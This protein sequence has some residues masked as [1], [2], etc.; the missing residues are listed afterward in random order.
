MASVSGT[1]RGRS[2]GGS[3]GPTASTPSTSSSTKVSPPHPPRP[4]L[5]RSDLVLVLHRDSDDSCR[6]PHSRSVS[7]SNQEEPPSQGKPAPPPA[8]ELH[9]DPP[10][11]FQILVANFLAQTEALM[12]GK[13][14][15]EAR[16]E[17]AAAG[18]EAAALQ[19]L[20]PHKVC[21][22]YGNRCR[23]GG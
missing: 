7:A 13:T 10:S 5:N 12:K 23:R 18:V 9:T 16:E 20:L 17:L 6:L 19:K 21:R 8:P 2:C 3:P 1:R 15:E 22:C 4:P 14:P 11:L